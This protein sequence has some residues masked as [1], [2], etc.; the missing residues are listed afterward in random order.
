[1]GFIGVA[2]DVT[3]AKRAQEELRQINETLEKRVEERTAQLAAS[4]A[5]VGSFFEHSSE[6]HAILVE[7]DGGF[8]YPGGQS[9]DPSPLWNGQE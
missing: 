5:L 7:D 9:G 1:M 8:R 2:H 6:C 3:D 4:E